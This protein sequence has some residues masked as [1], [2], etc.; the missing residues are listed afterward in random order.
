MF[1]GT[2]K[3]IKI[4]ADSDISP[5]EY[6]EII[7]R[8]KN[9]SVEKGTVIYTENDNNKNI[10]LI[11]SGEVTVSSESKS[12]RSEKMHFGDDHFLYND[13]KAPETVTAK[14]DTAMGVLSVDSLVTV[15]RAIARLNSKDPKARWRRAIL[16]VQAMNRI[17]RMVGGSAGKDFD[18]IRTASK[19]PTELSALHRHR[20][21]GIG[22]F[23]KGE[24]F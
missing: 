19:V 21:L 7:S 11:E 9:V 3:S 20:I 6:E 8:I 1:F 10:Y 5:P 24:I 23:G 15:I 2:Q 22:A 4:F 14:V 13:N 17:G 16:K 18:T 12:E